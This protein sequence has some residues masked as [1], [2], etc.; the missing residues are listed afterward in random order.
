MRKKNMD[1]FD[2][3]RR[4]GW[5]ADPTDKVRVIVVHDESCPAATGRAC[6][7]SPRLALSAEASHRAE[8][9]FDRGPTLLD[10]ASGE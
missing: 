1:Y 7:C 8:R 3:L 6:W 5:I 9:D 10:R 4:E 2:V